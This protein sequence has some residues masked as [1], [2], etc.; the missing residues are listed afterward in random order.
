MAIVRVTRFNY[1]PELPSPLAGTF[2]IMELPSTHKLYSVEP[3]W[4]GNKQSVS[5][6]PEGIYTMRYRNSGVVT[7]STSG[8]FT[9]GW[10]ITDVPNRTF[11][12]IHPGNTPLDFEGCVGPGTDYKLMRDHTGTLRLGV[13]SSRD[14]FRLLM[15]ELPVNQ[16]HQIHI[17]PT[18]IEYP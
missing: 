4:V 15:S 12:M 16:D 6:I 5:C 2:G 3:P 10:E 7:R 13:T 14:A 8:E 9:G 17:L 18:L 1:G 11:I